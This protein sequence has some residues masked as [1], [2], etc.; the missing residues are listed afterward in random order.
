MRREKHAISWFPFHP[1]RGRSLTKILSWMIL[2]SIMPRI[3]TH[4][5]SHS[6]RNRLI[7]LAALCLLLSAWANPAAAVPKT[8]VITLVNGD[9]ITCEIKEMVRG[10]VRASTDNMGTVSIEWDKITKVVSNY[11]FLVSLKDGSLIYGQMAES[12]EIGYLVVNFQERSTSL[13]MYEVVKIEPIRYDLWDRIDLSVAFGFNWNKGSQVLQSNFD[14]AAKYKGK[15]YSYGIDA[16]AMITD[17]GEGD[18]TR[19]NDSNIFLGRELSGRF[20]GSIDAGT[21]RNDELGIRFRV[22]GGGNLG[23]FLVRSSNHELRAIAGA[24]LNREWA[25]V[26]AD[27]S[28]NAEGRVGTE[29]TMFYYDTP[30]SDITVQADFYPSFTDSERFRFEGS[31]SGRQEI[32]KDLFIKVEFYESHDSKPPAS[33]TATEDR[34]LILSIE[35]TK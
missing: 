20:H 1:D 16:S 4:P 29:F 18:I 3:S 22:F 21:F 34:G 9:I 7:L 11:W 30:K 24:S 35:W 28:N 19:R 26:E 6:L 33:D 27:P 12:E 5:P 17:R 13:P 10:K 31:I 2:V 14:A 32:I 8:D 15:I 23:Y 25:S